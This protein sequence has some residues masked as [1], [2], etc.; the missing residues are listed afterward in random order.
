MKYSIILL[1]LFYYVIDSKAQ[2]NY[3]YINNKELIKANKVKSVN[4]FYFNSEFDSVLTDI[5]TFDTSGYLLCRRSFSDDGHIIIS[6]TSLYDVNHYLIKKIN[7]DDTGIVYINTFVNNPRG[8]VISQTLSRDSIFTQMNS[9]YDEKDR[10]VKTIRIIIGVDTT[11]TTF[12]YNAKGQ[13]IKNISLSSKNGT[14]TITKEYNSAGKVQK[15][16]NLSQDS[17]YL[18]EFKYDKNGN[19]YEIISTSTDNNKKNTLRRLYSYYPDGLLF[20]KIIFRNNKP[21]GVYRAFYT[22][23]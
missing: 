15:Q 7:Y 2:F 13:D 9:S 18:F 11:I 1:I 3:E 17:K 10:L 22:Y 12:F 23:Y 5:N 20:E 8:K 6:D 4:V 14:S 19:N 16:I 21:L